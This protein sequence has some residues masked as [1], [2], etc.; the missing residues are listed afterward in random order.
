MIKVCLFCVGCF[1]HVALTAQTFVL[2]SPLLKSHP[3]AE[4]KKGLALITA[5]FAAL[6]IAVEFR[7]RP[8]KRSIS[9]VNNGVADG[10]FV[11][12][13]SI[14]KSYPNVIVVPEPLSQ[15]ELVAI[16]LR[17]DIDLAHYQ[18]NQHQYRV[19]YL[20]GWKVVQNLLDGHPNKIAVG[21]FDTL[22]KLL[23]HQRL[24][25][26]LFNQ[27]AAEK[28]LNSL[29]ID[30]YQISP[31]LLSYTTFLVLNKKHRALVPRLAAQLKRIKTES[32]NQ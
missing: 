13:A 7:Y 27:A 18:I 16:A 1:F 8:D 15:M 5:G 25:L 14:N 26:V 19:G 30:N 9:E 29:K 3:T 22:F 21:E 24:D 32:L 10:D 6:D 20:T 28:L 31:S 2:N 17:S 11:R 23:L 4:V 12:I